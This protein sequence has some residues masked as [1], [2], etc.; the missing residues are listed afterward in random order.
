MLERAVGGGD[1]RRA[2][3][4]IAAVTAVVSGV[5]VFVNGYGVRAWAGVADATTYTTLK[6]VVAATFLVAV[7]AVATRRRRASGVVK[8]RGLGQ[9]AGLAVVAVIGGAVPFVLFFEG[10][11]RV[12]SAQAAFIHKTLVIWVVILAVVLLRER[13]GVLHLTAV[14]LLVLGQAALVGGLDKLSFG[15]G[16]WM[17]LAATL[18]WSVEVIV[19]KKLLVN[20]T[21]LTL[22]IARMVGGA[23]LLIGYGIVRGSLAEMS[24]LSLRHILW[25]LLTGLVLAAYVGGWYG[26][27]ARA[28]AADVTAVLVG[29]ALITAMLRWGVD[30]VALP[31]GVG[32]GLVG[33]GVTLAI[34]AGWP[35]PR[36]IASS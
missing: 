4:L 1:K 33:C 29:G 7:A 3:I 20:L 34:L 31:S 17:M 11:A 30:G 23:A 25:V 15:T 6:N 26:A 24:G 5:A 36:T 28:Q 21:P 19:A 2:G 32:L 12:S 10:F 13:I 14:A 16:E 35:R 8:P 27:L 18:F 9:W 22:G